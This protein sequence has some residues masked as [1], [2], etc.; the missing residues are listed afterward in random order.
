[1]ELTLAPD[2]AAKGL[3]LTLGYVCNPAVPTSQNDRSSVLIVAVG[4]GKTGTKWVKCLLKDG[5]RL[6]LSPR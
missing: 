2:L 1:M 3:L 6:G 4:I 5:A